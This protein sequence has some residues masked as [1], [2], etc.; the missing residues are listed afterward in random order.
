MTS[1]ILVNVW[2]SYPLATLLFLRRSRPYRRSC[3]RPRASTAHRPW[4]SSVH[5]DPDMQATI[6]VVVIQLTL[7]YFNMVTLIYVLTGGGPLA[8]TQ[9]LALRV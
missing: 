5:H 1:V 9:T 7:Q 2:A 8:G 3:T 4:R 6:L